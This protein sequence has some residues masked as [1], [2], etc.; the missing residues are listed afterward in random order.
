MANEA[1]TNA[2][3]EAPG[4]PPA[5]EQTEQAVI[6]GMDGGPAP[7]GKVIDLSDARTET[8][9]TGPEAPAPGESPLEQG[10][11]GS[12]TEHTKQEWERPLA[13]IEAEQKKTHRGRPPKAD[14]ASPEAGEKETAKPYLIAGIIVEA[15]ILKGY[16]EEVPYTRAEIFFGGII[17]I[18]TWPIVL[19][20]H[21]II[22]GG[23]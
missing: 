15:F 23:R 19:L 12:V 10:A 3:L 7:S 1:K 17:D 16:T 13:E 22:N 21:I 4:G 18:L 20:V 14:R 8:G 5:P 11:A 6:P 9:K 2:T